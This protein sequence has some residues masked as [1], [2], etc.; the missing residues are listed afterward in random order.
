[1]K[2]IYVELYFKYSEL[3]IIKLNTIRKYKNKYFYDCIFKVKY[4]NEN[5]EDMLV[6]LIKKA[7]LEKNKLVI[8]YIYDNIT[9]LK[10][11]V[12]KMNN[13]E[14]V[15]NIDIEINN[16]VSNY[17]ELYEYEV[18]KISSFKINEYRTVL[19]P[20]NNSYLTIHN[21]FFKDMKI[22]K[23]KEVVNYQII[24]TIMKS[25]KYKS[26]IVY[27]IIC[28]NESNIEFYLLRNGLVIELMVFDVDNS[29]L[30]LYNTSYNYTELLNVNN[31]Y[32]K[33]ICF[34]LNEFAS[35]RNVE[36]MIMIFNNKYNEYLKKLIDQE[37]V[38]NHMVRDYEETI[39]YAIEELLYEK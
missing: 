17:K 34:N 31:Q 4:Q 12:P 13:L 15:K 25:Y 10:L 16:L 14:M 30:K 3:E 5:L 11:S 27:G 24:E 19:Y 26:N 33:N 2:I 28:F 36:G 1:M 8:N 37:I 38:I 9:F 20:K 29:L 21:Y 7:N 23:I 35:N 39:L 32:F 18:S 22:N 6:H